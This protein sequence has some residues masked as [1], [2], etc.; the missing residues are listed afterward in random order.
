[1]YILHTIYIYVILLIFTIA[2]DTED[3]DDNQQEAYNKMIMPGTH[4][5]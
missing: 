3:D 4:S 5:L 1:M 2:N